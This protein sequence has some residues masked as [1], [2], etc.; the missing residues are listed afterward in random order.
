MQLQQMQLFH[1]QALIAGQWCDADNQQTSE[2]Y[3]PATQE[4]IGT[5][6]NM[7]KA[8]A[9]RAIQAAVKHWATWKNKTAKDR[10]II[11]KKWFDLMVAHADE[12]AFILTS[13]Q[14]KPLAEARGEILYAASFVEWFAEEAKRVYGDTI[15]SPYPDARII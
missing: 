10:S 4:M 8:E 15:P 11:L 9:D 14:G 3:N 2:I 12:L 1:Q 13:E 5:V 6:P 7:G